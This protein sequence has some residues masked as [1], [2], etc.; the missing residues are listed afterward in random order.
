MWETLL[1]SSVPALLVLAGVIYNDWRKKKNSQ[2][3]TQAA[4]Q[5][6]REPT[7]VE[8]EESNR[9]LRAEMADQK[10]EAESRIAGLEA[11]FNEFEARTEKREKA[12]FRV[13][14]D[15]SIQWP[16]SHPGPLFDSEDLET[17]ADTIPSRWRRRFR[18]SSGSIPL[19]S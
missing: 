1:V 17:L 5:N 10:T 4:I 8:L 15:A 7:W 13:L 12:M 16:E 2:I 9:K 6:K 19:T 18:P 3:D 11:R 14:N